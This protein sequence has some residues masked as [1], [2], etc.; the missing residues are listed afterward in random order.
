MMMCMAMT[1]RVQIPVDEAEL[2]LYRTAAERA[3]LPLA[4]WARRKLRQ[5]ALNAGLDTEMTPQEAVR[6][7]CSLNAPVAPLK[8]MIWESYDSRYE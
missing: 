4:E 5:E 6:K 8:Q 7:L 1:K 3:G 2:E